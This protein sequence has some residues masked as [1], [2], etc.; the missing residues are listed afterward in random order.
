MLGEVGAALEFG[1]DQEV[2]DEPPQIDRIEVL[3]LDAGP[4][5]ELEFRRA[6]I[7]LLVSVDHLLAQREISVEQGPGRPRRLPRAPVRRG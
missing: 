6:V 1:Q 4:D 3:G 5:L 2:A 7:H